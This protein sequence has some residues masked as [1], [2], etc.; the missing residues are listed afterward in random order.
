MPGTKRR[1]ADDAASGLSLERAVALS[2]G[3]FSIAATLL[4]I[5]VRLPH[6]GVPFSWSMLVEIGPR[7]L[8]Y[9]ISF[10]VIG[11]MWVAHHRKLRLVE[12]LDIRALWLNLL[13]LMFIAFLPFPT[14]V[15]SEH[16]DRDAVVF[17]AL[18]IASAALMLLALWLYIGRHG[19]WFAADD[20]AARFAHERTRTVA[21]F[22]VF[23][24]S[25]PIAFVDVTAAMLSWILVA[26]VAVWLGYRG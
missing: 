23:L 21:L 18:T 19:D 11:Q 2:D 16:A 14:A 12:R 20:W 22:G 1:A 13:F 5:D 7:L 17:Y 6:P 3:V 25:A 8:G 26:P 4:I 24:L 9:V 10:L 15:L